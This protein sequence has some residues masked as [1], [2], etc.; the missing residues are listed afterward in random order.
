VTYTRDRPDELLPSRTTVTF[1]IEREQLEGS[2]VIDVTT[3][4]SVRSTV[5]DDDWSAMKVV[6]ICV[7][8]DSFTPDP[9]TDSLAST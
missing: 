3:L 7:A 2:S 5:D 4:L 1:V 9:T 8:W 6:A